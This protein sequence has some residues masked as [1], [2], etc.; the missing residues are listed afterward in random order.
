M[1]FGATNTKTTRTTARIGGV[2][3]I[4]AGCMTAVLTLTWPLV[5]M[6]TGAAIAAIYVFYR[7]QTSALLNKWL[8]LGLT[9]A[10]VLPVWIVGP[11]GDLETPR[12][13]TT[14]PALFTGLT[15]AARVLTTV[16]VMLLIGGCLSPAGVSRA[17]AHICGKDI[18]LACAIGVNLLPAVLEMLRRTALAM[19]LRGGFRRNRIANLKRL[20][21]AVGVQTVRL[22]EDV[23]E[24]LLLAEPPPND[25]P[26][27]TETTP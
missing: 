24:A 2:L 18:A 8:W 20:L 4:G 19:R 6:P 5:L 22:T 10:V 27:R 11:P 12:G 16:S 3:I 13:G 17:L 15:A 7:R 21:V 1:V 9:L 26:D 14:L 23:A 25:D